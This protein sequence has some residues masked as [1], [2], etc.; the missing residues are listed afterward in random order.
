MAKK[1]KTQRGRRHRSRP[2]DRD[3]NVVIVKNDKGEIVPEPRIVVLVRAQA[4]HQ[5][6]F[7]NETD[8]KLSFDVGTLGNITLEKPDPTSNTGSSASITIDSGSTRARH[9]YKP[10]KFHAPVGHEQA[11]DPEIIIE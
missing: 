9:Q 10:K 1:A 11:G 4:K 7:W 8:E 5:L 6:T 3:T 2:P